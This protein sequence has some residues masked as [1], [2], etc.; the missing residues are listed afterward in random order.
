[1]TKH[2]ITVL[3]CL[4]TARDD[5]DFW[6]HMG[7]PHDKRAARELEKM[8]FVVIEEDK[9]GKCLWVAPT[10]K[11]VAEIRA[12]FENTVELIADGCEWKAAT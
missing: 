7:T 5:R 8:G 12:R 10:R 11:G 1:M 9:P 4:R 2:Q 6:S 3:A